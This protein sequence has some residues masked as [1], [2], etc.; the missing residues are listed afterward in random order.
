MEGLLWRT[1]AFQQKFLCQACWQ[2]FFKE[3]LCCRSSSIERAENPFLRSQ[4]HAS[5]DANFLATLPQ[6]DV[7]MKKQ[8]CY[9]RLPTKIWLY[10]S[11]LTMKIANQAKTLMILAKSNTQIICNS[12]LTKV[13]LNQC[14]L[15]IC[16]WYRRLQ[17]FRCLLHKYIVNLFSPPFL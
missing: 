12:R 9:G 6:Q 1:V 16:W 5:F 13:K 3:V 15:W 14:P 7:R 10:E 17:Y 11:F 8:I 2:Y 4:G